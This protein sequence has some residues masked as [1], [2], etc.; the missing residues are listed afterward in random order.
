M[1]IVSVKLLNSS[2]N[3][4]ESPHCDSFHLPRLTSLPKLDRHC[5]FEKEMYFPAPGLCRTLIQGENFFRNQQCALYRVIQTCTMKFL[6]TLTLMYKI[7]VLEKTKDKIK[8]LAKTK[9]KI[10]VWPTGDIE[11][12][13]TDHRLPVQDIVLS[14]ILSV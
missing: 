4:V 12:K 3:V 5:D 10:K 14:E 11:S 8:V 6:L 2:V 1:N 9:D 7:K 13:C